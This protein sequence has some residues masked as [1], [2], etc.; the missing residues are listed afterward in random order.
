MKLYRSI[1]FSKLQFL[2]TDQQYYHWITQDLNFEDPYRVNWWLDHKR[3]E[4]TRSERQK[5]ISTIAKNENSIFFNK[6]AEYNS[7][8]GGRFN[9]ARSF[10]GVYCANSPL[11]SALEV[12]YHYITNTLETISPVSKN[13]SAVQASYNSRIGTKLDVVIASFEFELKKDVDFGNSFYNLNDAGSDGIEDLKKLCCDLGFERY[14]SDHF[15][16]DFIFG[17]NY[18]ISHILGC[19]L[20]SFD[21]NGF[22]VP[23]ARLDYNIQDSLE[24]RNLFIPEKVLSDI[25]PEL[26]GKFIEYEFQFEVQLNEN[27]KY[28]IFI[29]NL[30]SEFNFQLEMSPVRNSV[31]AKN[32]IKS[33]EHNV[34][35]DNKKLREVYLQRFVKHRG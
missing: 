19:H 6:S 2:L 26:T 28:E 23:S 22:K 31:V 35:A 7:V 12:L 5:I 24:L 8:T 13:R 14:L 29:S 3:E 25:K 32:Q 27:N 16:R 17:N 18:E 1:E 21:K 4:E 9:P 30:G 33:Y 34:K 10:G 11:M 20:H 15:D